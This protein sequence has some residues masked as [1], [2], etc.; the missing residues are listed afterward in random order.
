MSNNSVRHSLI[1]ENAIPLPPAQ[2]GLWAYSM[3]N[4]MPIFDYILEDL[5]NPNI[6]EI[7]VE[8][9]TSGRYFS[10][11]A[12]KHAGSY[13]GIDPFLPANAVDDPPFI[14]YYKNYS[15]NYLS[16][17]K[18]EHNL[19]IIDG[20]HNFTTVSKEL[21]AIHKR[22]SELGRS[23][24]IF[25]HDV[26]WPCGKRDAFYDLSRMPDDVV[27]NSQACASVDLNSEKLIEFGVGYGYDIGWRTVI[28]GP[29]NGVL[30][31]LEN[32]CD[33]QKDWK[34]LI[35]PAFFGLAVV[36][37]NKNIC[38]LLKQ[39]LDQLGGSLKIIGT[40]VAN[41]EYNRISFY[42]EHTKLLASHSKLNNHLNDVSNN[43]PKNLLL[44]S[45]QLKKITTKLKIYLYWLMPS[46]RDKYRMMLRSLVQLVG[47]IED[48][49]ESRH[50]H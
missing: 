7:G 9:G 5:K 4:F 33:S 19:F 45:I 30:T 42:V 35:I 17:E 28:G 15:E 25:M 47:N 41:L 50:Q 40:T 26:T 3:L 29:E 13:S 37:D 22:S 16:N 31:A 12:I 49:H 2:D 39:K 34:Y 27:K 38:P 23:P 18:W 14:K 21:N 43:L 48:I 46:R 36:W 44:K 8:Y 1:D 11:L 10:N 6:C 32:F 24:L 20:D